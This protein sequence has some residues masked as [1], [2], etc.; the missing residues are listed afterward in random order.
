MAFSF[1]HI[2]GKSSLAQGIA[3]PKSA[4]PYLSLPEKGGKRLISLIYANNRRSPAILRRLNNLRGHVQIRYEGKTGEQFRQWLLEN[5]GEPN[6]G[7]INQINNS[8][9]ITIISD[10]VL[11][12]RTSLNRKRNTLCFSDLRVH[13][14][15]EE[16][17]LTQEEF[18]E[19][20][21]SVRNVEF[22]QDERQVYYNNKI[23]K[24]L[25]VKG[26]LK[27]QKI[28]QTDPNV[29]LRCDFRKKAWQLEIEFG[30]ARTYYQDIVK[31][32]MSYSTG[33]MKI[34]GLIVPD[35]QFA[36]HLCLLGKK[37]AVANRPSDDANYSGMMHFSKA[38]NEFEYIKRI[39]KIP[40]FI[41]AISHPKE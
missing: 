33:L 24:E 22:F 11:D 16:Q 18:N 14:I 12:I 5:F 30:N 29:R 35:Y 10:D 9:D 7:T 40:F 8:L 2:V 34:G 3:I 17:L 20:I 26:W 32:A 19:I 38:V 15:R 36:K 4:Y 39:F 13:G 23:D 28:V 1:S 25:S 6:F 37:N 21:S 31:F 41:A 27:E